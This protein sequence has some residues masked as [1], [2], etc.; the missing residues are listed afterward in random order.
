MVPGST[1]MYGSSLRMETR[2]SRA[3]RI[4]PMLAAVMPFPSEEVTPPVTKTYFAMGSVLRGFFEC[5]R[6]TRARAR[7]ARSSRLREAAPTRVTRPPM[8]LCQIPVGW[9]QAPDR[10]DGT[11][12]W[13]PEVD[14][15]G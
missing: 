11:L 8:Q 1:L 2:R 13:H 15:S 4:R 7:R 14:D 6:I 5:Y 12:R 9:V 3:L 10:A